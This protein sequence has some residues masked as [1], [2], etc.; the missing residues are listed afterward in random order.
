MRMNQGA[1]GDLADTLQASYRL[2]VRVSGVEAQ[3]TY[4]VSVTSRRKGVRVL[5]RSAFKPSTGAAATQTVERVE[6]AVRSAMKDERR[7]GA[8]RLAPRT[9]PLKLTW[10]G[11]KKDFYELEVKVPYDALGFVP[12]E[13]SMVASARLTITPLALGTAKADPVTEDVFL[14]LTGAE[15]SATKGQDLTRVVKLSLPPG[16]F[17]LTVTI[18]DALLEKSAGLER[19]TV[20]AA[21]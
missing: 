13:D 3:K 15:Y 12:E 17:Q 11:K 19:I 6:D 20:E 16:R 14:A 10:K 1:I 5:A 4:K 8:A 2:A 21:P 7:P 9:I 18:E